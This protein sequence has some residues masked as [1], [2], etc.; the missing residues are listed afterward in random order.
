MPSSS[1]A[2][3]LYDMETGT[4]RMRRA[5]LEEY[6]RRVLSRNPHVIII[7]E[8]PGYQGTS[9]TGVPFASEYHL[10]GQSEIDF[11]RDTSGFTRVAKDGLSK[12]PT[13]TIM[14]RTIGQYERLP[15]LWAVYPLHPH[16][17]GNTASNRTP[18]PAEVRSGRDQLVDLLDILQ[19]EKVVALGNIAKTTLDSLGVP[20]QKVRHPS[21]GG[22]AVF[23]QQL[24]ALM[25]Q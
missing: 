20:S 9:R 5:N 18:T 21:R 6:F 7:G 13:S 14:W 10:G 16:H 12:E 17:P 8:A 25:L 1:V 23:A 19:P 3:N 2:E 4:G 22:A 11:F 15:I 24:D